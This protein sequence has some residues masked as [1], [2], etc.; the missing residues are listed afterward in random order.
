MIH[1][2]SAADFAAEAG[3]PLC[4]LARSFEA[5]RQV[6]EHVVERI[7]VDKGE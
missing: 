6:V 5:L 2:L 4:P 1:E 3:F 7:V